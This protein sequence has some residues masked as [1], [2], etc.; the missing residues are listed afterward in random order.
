MSQISPDAH[1]IIL[2]AMRSGTTSLFHSLAQHPQ[3]C[4]STVKEPEY[5]SQHQEH[6]I[7]VDAYQDLWKFQAGVHR[8]ALEA[9][10]GYAKFPQE[11][12]APERIAA[13]GLNPRFLFIVRDPF[14]R[15]E[16][17]QRHMR[18]LGYDNRHGVMAGAYLV[19]LSN[20]MLQLRRF[21]AH[22]PRE[23]F[24]IIDFEELQSNAQGVVDD[25]CEFLQL[26]PHPLTHVTSLNASREVSRLK[27][28]LWQ[29]PSLHQLVR[30]LMPLGG[31]RLLSAW[32]MRWS[33]TEQHYRLNEADRLLVF[34]AL[35][36]D[37]L[38]F[39]KV[40]GFDVSRWGF[41]PH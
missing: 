18:R 21:L 14:S 28:W 9:S 40:F 22:F 11:T 33:S 3:I 27:E 31:R 30:R 4:P 34:N 10:T 7:A 16:S 24:L 5:F 29:Y 37:M 23:N 26:S 41:R 20:Y 39:Q 15:I 12:A 2:G 13:A 19:Y 1:L 36:D 38:E 6:R 25:I 35:H 8:Y 17:Q 32:A